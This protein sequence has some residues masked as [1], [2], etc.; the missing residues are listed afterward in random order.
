VG[1]QGGDAVIEK[2]SR[3]LLA[4]L[5]LAL[6]V[7]VGCGTESPASPSA[8]GKHLGERCE[9]TEDCASSLCVR[10]D[11][12]G[13]ICSQACTDDSGCPRGDNWG[14]APAPGQPFSVCACVPLGDKE[15]C[16]DG[17]DNDCN[18][19]TDDCRYC[20]GERVAND[21][22]DHCGSCDNACRSD[23]ACHSGTCECQDAA[24]SECRG[25][26]VLL[27]Q[28]AQNCGECGKSCGPDQTCQNGQCACATGQSYCEGLGCFD[29]QTDSDH[30]GDC[31]TVCTEGQ[32]CRA[33]SCVCSDAAR[34][35]YCPG[36][37]C[38]DLKT[39]SRHCG[40]CDKTCPD[41][42]SCADGACVCAT[43]RTD[44]DGECKDTQA[45]AENCGECGNA[46]PAPL[47]CIKG[48]CGCSGDGYSICGE[49]CASLET[50]VKNCGKCGNVCD[51]GEICSNG[52]CL[53]QSGLSCD[54]VCMRTDDDKN[55]GSCGNA[56][57]IGQRCSGSTC[58]CEGAGLTECTGDCLDLS[59]D[60]QSCGAC[61]KA[62]NTGE[63]CDF[64]SCNCPYAT[65]YCA[66]ADACVPLAND[67]KNC[68]ACGKQCNP[69]EVCTGGNCACPVAG[70]IYC[71]TLGACV[72]VQSSTA[73]C[74]ACATKCKATETCQNGYCDCPN[75]SEQYCVSQKAC[76]DIYS[77]DKH[78]GACDHAC[79]AATHCAFGSCDCTAAGQTLCSDD[80][81]YDLSTN[82]ANCGT[83][84]KACDANQVCTAGQCSCP[85]P[86][87]GTAVRL[88]NTALTESAPVVAFNGTN[89]GVLYLQSG[90]GPAP[91]NLRFALLKPDGSLV[92]DAA[93]TAFTDPNVGDS[94]LTAGSLVWTGTEFGLIYVKQKAFNTQQLLLQRLN[95]NGTSKAAPVVVSTATPQTI[96]LGWSASYAGY[97]ASYFSPTSGGMVWRRI[98]PTGT[99]PENESLL[100]GGTQ[101]GHGSQL[102]GPADGT[103]GLNL[104]GNLTWFN[105]DGSRTLPI[106]LLTG[107]VSLSHDGAN[108]LATFSNDSS[109][110]VQRGTTKNQAVL[111]T[112]TG[113]NE[114]WGDH[115]S[116]LAGKNLAVLLAKRTDSLG[117]STLLF[118]RFVVPAGTSTAFTAPTAPIDMLPG[119]TVAGNNA[120][121][122]N[123]ALVATGPSA[124]LALWSDWRWGVAAELYSAPITIPNCP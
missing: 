124:L 104:A 64:G 42:Q 36:I 119:P 43:G 27:L 73:H 53:C 85:A 67:E 57:P 76:T 77:N 46:C 110:L 117:P 23:Q 15:V 26:C 61:D 63:S 83:C 6:L 114:Y 81:C 79:P 105:A 103:W 82:A 102:I 11:E 60:E 10:V 69:T 50:D 108:W 112:R 91:T 9:K 31:D 54:G 65:T 19:A 71:A 111:W 58:V 34:G 38:L 3:A 41:G 21:A 39:D 88:T 5:L 16:G 123:F 7:L 99:T 94:V 56:C 14:C 90:T 101:S 35:D 84:G 47:T 28:D 116:A 78:C 59:K 122:R 17:L 93:L 100:S 37:G 55:C 20:D 109:L 113:F 87:V 22:H 12:K 86:T 95:A 30:C 118:Q 52:G 68:G 33:G 72:D 70:Q 49:R 44:C 75:Y 25:S 92:S 18:G 2:L 45:D 40:D 98:G 97:A 120:N 74:G 13:G 24:M 115:T 106:M 8:I 51:A 66:G 32:V 29:F 62:C 48:E 4:S 96:A 80:K 121:W 1:L 107:D 89:V